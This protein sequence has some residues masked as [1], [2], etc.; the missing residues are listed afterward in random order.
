MSSHVASQR[1]RITSGERSYRHFFP[2]PCRGHRRCCI[3]CSGKSAISRSRAAIRMDR[4]HGLNEQDSPVSNAGGDMTFLRSGRLRKWGGPAA[5]LL[6]AALFTAPASAWAGC[7]HS[8]SSRSDRLTS[9]H[10][11]DELIMNGSTRSL[12]HQADQSPFTPPADP[13]RSPCSGLSCSNSSMPLPMST[14]S[15]G[16]DGRDR[17][18]TLSA[19]VV[20]DNSTFYNRAD[21]EPSPAPAGGQSGVFHPP[22]V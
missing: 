19:V 20:A 15:P 17:W 9:L 22:R 8:V 4:P 12:R 11:L 10:Q 3:V 16:P 21:D 2:A 5:L 1:S 7:D 13:R 6:A 18:G 14:S